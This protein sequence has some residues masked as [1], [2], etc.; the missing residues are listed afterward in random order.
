MIDS[1]VDRLTVITV[2]KMVKKEHE[3]HSA[4]DSLY[5]VDS[6]LLSTNSTVPDKDLYIPQRG[7]VQMS[8][9]QEGT[10]TLTFSTL[11]HI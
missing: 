4:I 5:H 3:Q 8:R 11:Q 10:A 6:Q 9:D 7:G 1:P 2:Q